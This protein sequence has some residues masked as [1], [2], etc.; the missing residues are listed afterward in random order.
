[1]DLNTKTIPIQYNTKIIVCPKC[2]AEA[3][4][5]AEDEIVICAVCM[6]KLKKIKWYGYHLV[7]D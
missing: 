4:M 7:H 1:M 5:L 6:H 2:N 3:F